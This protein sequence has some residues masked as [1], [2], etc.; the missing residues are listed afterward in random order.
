MESVWQSW[1]ALRGLTVSGNLSVFANNPTLRDLLKPEAVW[2][3]EQGQRY[4]ALDIYKASSTRSSLFAAFL[5]LFETVDYV[6]LPATQCMPFEADL[7]WPKLIAG[8][9]MDTYHRWMECTIY[10]SLAGLPA[11]SMPAG[12]LNGLPFGLQ[13]IGK[14]N[15]EWS[16][17]Q[18]S[19][20]WQAAKPVAAAI[21]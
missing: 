4:S 16:L 8:R 3:F 11:M 6:A 7:D 14:P 10:A 21:S 15:D 17:L 19:Y 1:L 5:T 20:A 9:S 2:E 12:L 13:I 18:L